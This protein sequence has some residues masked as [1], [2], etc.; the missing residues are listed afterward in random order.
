M[1]KGQSICA[2]EVVEIKIASETKKSTWRLNSGARMLTAI[3][4][5]GDV[6]LVIDLSGVTFEQSRISMLREHGRR[7]SVV[8]DDSWYVNPIGHWENPRVDE[9][10]IYGQPVV[11]TPRTPFEE[12]MPL[13]IEGG[14]VA[15]LIERNHPWQASVK[16]TG[17][18]ERVAPGQ[19]V[20][21]NGRI[22]IASD[23]LDAPP[24]MICR[25]GIIS[26]ASICLFGADSNTGSVAASRQSTDKKEIPVMKERLTAL[27]KA[28]NNKHAGKIAVALSLGKTD[29]EIAAELSAADAAD[30]AAIITEKDAIIE[31]SKTD[32]ATSTAK[33]A[34]LQGKLDALKNEGDDSAQ[35]TATKGESSNS[36]PRTVQAGMALLAR[37]NPKLTGFKLRSATLTRWPDLRADLPKA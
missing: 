27:L 20:T 24:L 14:E 7:A 22:E 36:K 4:D 2:S 19:S 9:T 21:V 17:D 37:E 23:D 10:G 28:H 1:M 30:T 35:V 5:F 8:A 13:M 31:K 26:E 11:Y 3:R 33:V 15:A 12:K 16:I 25:T 29:E 34:E 6:E 32:L 18:Y